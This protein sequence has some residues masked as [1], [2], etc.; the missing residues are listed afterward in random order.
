MHQH[1]Y[2]TPVRQLWH[3]YS[4]RLVHTSES[5]V[6]KTGAPTLHLLV[7]NFHILVAH[8]LK[9]LQSA[10]YHKRHIKRYHEDTQTLCKSKEERTE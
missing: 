4:N 9:C 6:R 5:A 2:S 10:S 1:L 7:Q 8:R 3:I